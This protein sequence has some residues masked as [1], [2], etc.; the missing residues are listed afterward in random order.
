MAHTLGSVGMMAEAK[1]KR[2][3]IQ[4]HRLTGEHFCEF[5]PRFFLK[6]CRRLAGRLNVAD[7]FVT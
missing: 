3:A 7:M 2:D 4:M 6:L 5:K 1:Y